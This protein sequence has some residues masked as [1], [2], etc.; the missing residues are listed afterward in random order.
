MRQTHTSTEYLSK[1]LSQYDLDSN[2]ISKLSVS[3]NRIVKGN[4]QV[5]ITP[6]AKRV[7]PDKILQEWNGIFNSKRNLMNSDLV[8]ME[9]SQIS[10]FGPRS[11]AKPWQDWKEEVLQSFR[12]ERRDLDYLQTG[13]IYSKDIGNLRPISLANAKKYV[14]NR[15]KSGLPYMQDKGDV[16]DKT[17]NEFLK[18]L[19]YNYP[20]IPALRTQEQ[21]KTR[22][23]QM[24][25]LV[26]ILE[27]IRY[28]VPLFNYLRDWDCFSSMKGPDFTDQ[29]VTNIF[30]YAVKEDQFIVSGDIK[31]F[32]SNFGKSIQTP[33]FNDLSLLFQPQ[34]REDYLETGRVFGSIGLVT[35]DG[36]LEGDHGIPSGSQYTNKVGSYGNFK[37]CNEPPE[38]TSFT[39]DDFLVTSNNVKQIFDRYDAAG[40][41]LNEDKTWVR[42][43]SATYLQK[44]YHPDYT[45]DGVL[46]GVYPTYR[47]LNRLCYPERYSDFTEF[48][49]SGSDYFAIR[50]L[51]ILE[52]CKYHP[53]FEDLVKLWLK[54]SHTNI[55]SNRGIDAYVK[56]YRS[57]QGSVGT[58]NQY[59][60]N[61]GIR[62]W[63]SFKLISRLA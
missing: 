47:A 51:S 24:F 39:G 23:V 26:N 50:S 35:P 31:N 53:L 52:N 36:L 11:I 21:G 20:C 42:K 43:S 49:I 54:H 48:K 59:G 27:E 37:V 60:D 61:T 10:K 6:P 5:L 18:Q 46:V 30:S 40:L 3:L 7:G 25:P 41:P 56:M 29:Q 34:Y 19:G 28:F 14:K 63:E 12:I 1:R 57:K 13:P 55:P 16:V 22:L 32:D 4:D 44:L 62:S 15:S 2:D 8:E 58:E 33:I 38:T 9:E 45:R 17:I